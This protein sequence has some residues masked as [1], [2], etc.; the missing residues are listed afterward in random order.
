MKRRGAPARPGCGGH[1][2]GQRS[3][4]GDVEEAPPPNLPRTTAGAVA[5]LTAADVAEQ[6]VEAII[7]D[8]FWILTHDQYQ[9]VIR[10]HAAWIGT[11]AR[12]VPAPIW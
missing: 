4:L 8:R 12:P 5:T 6:V 7:S 9:T 10:Q 1:R 11:A 2:C 3:W